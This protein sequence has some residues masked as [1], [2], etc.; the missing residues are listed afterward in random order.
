MEIIRKIKSSE[1]WSDEFKIGGIEYPNGFPLIKVIP[2]DNDPKSVIAIA[3]LN[4]SL[5]K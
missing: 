3:K 5:N 1:H 4:D 2:P